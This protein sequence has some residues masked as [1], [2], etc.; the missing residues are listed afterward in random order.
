MYTL[1]VGLYEQFFAKQDYF[2]VIIGLDNAGKTT[3]LEQI[4]AKFIRD[5]GMLN[6]SK[7]TST[8]GM[9]VGKV[10]VGQVRLNFWDLGGQEDLR[11]LWGTYYAEASGVIFVVDG[12]RRDL[13][14]TVASCFSEAMKSEFVQR[15]PVLVAVNKSELDGAVSANEV[16]QLLSDDE[17]CSD[18]AVLP[19]SALEG[20]NIDRCVRW[21]V[22]SLQQTDRRLEL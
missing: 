19:V 10:E 18:L 5:Y 7:I 17:H 14:G 13:F 22:R 12:T 6:P 20:H 8:I 9:N 21:L 1:S 16:R 15:I 4:K 11:E 3:L 2:V